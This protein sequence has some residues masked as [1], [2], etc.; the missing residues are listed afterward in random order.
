MPSVSLRGMGTTKDTTPS[1][2]KSRP[3]NSSIFISAPWE[4]CVTRRRRDP[5]TIQLRD[6]GQQLAG[7]MVLGDEN[8]DQLQGLLGNIHGCGEHDDGRPWIQPPHLNG[9][10]LS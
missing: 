2:I 6:R 7:Q 8:V 9:Y 3:A 4:S 5:C 1:A 10:L